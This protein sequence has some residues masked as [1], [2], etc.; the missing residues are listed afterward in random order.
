MHTVLFSK[1]IY[2]LRF[3]EIPDKIQWEITK[4]CFFMGLYYGCFVFYVSIYI[5]QHNQW[6][7]AV[8]NE[9]LKIWNRDW[10]YLVFRYEPRAI[11]ITKFHLDSNL[12]R[13]RDHELKKDAL[14]SP[15][16]NIVLDTSMIIS[17]SYSIWPAV[18]IVRKHVL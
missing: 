16:Y 12:M 7:D 5:V 9:G 8:L 13:S 11:S 10:K 1:P 18:I 6:A 4:G 3:N 17:T 14:H 2:S 15:L